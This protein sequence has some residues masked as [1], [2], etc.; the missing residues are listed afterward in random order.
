M[1]LKL[2]IFASVLALMG[3]KDVVP[4]EKV[5]KA[6]TLMAS[7]TEIRVQFTSVTP[8]P[9][10]LAL[11]L[12]GGVIDADE[13]NEF[14]HF[15]SSVQVSTYRSEATVIFQLN[16]NQDAFDFYFPNGSVE[17]DSNIVNLKLFTRASCT[18]APVQFEELNGLE[19]NWEPVYVNGKDC[20]VSSYLG[21]LSVS[22]Q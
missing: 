15:S 12:N 2:L 5:G 4:I 8:L 7:S 22:L 21:I 3:C 6:C 14:N 19:A 20:G 1:A 13:C 9:S 18:D 11:S 10:N 16:G 17:P